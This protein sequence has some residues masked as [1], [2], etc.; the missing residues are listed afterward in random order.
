MSALAVPVDQVDHTAPWAACR[1]IEVDRQ[2]VKMTSPRVAMQCGIGMVFQPSSLVPALTV[3]EKL[4]LALE[5]PPWWVGRRARA[6]RA[7]D[8]QLHELAPGV[9]RKRPWRISPS[10][11]CN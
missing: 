9:G 3:R 4:V 10:A 11:S 5:A 7:L 2:P 1:R 8:E 6:L